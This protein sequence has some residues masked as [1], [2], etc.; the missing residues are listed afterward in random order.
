M[1]YDP[2]SMV[3]GLGFLH[4]SPKP[5]TLNSKPRPKLNSRISFDASKPC[6]SYFDLKV[7]R[8]DPKLPIPLNERICLK[9]Y[10]AQCHAFNK[11]SITRKFQ[12]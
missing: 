7:F 6:A 2:L 5:Q 9:S 4:R 8:K 3:P 11:N 1:S 12:D 10:G